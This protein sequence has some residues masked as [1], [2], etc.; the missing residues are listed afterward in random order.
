MHAKVKTEASTK[1]SKVIKK[2]GKVET[3]CV[4]MRSPAWGYW[5]FREHWEAKSHRRFFFFCHCE[6]AL[7]GQC[8]TLSPSSLCLLP[9]YEVGLL[10]HVGPEDQ[11]NP[12]YIELPNSEWAIIKL[13]SSRN[14]YCGYFIIVTKSNRSWSHMVSVYLFGTLMV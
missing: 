14:D 3:P 4:K 11:A 10:Y 6:Y 9:D 13:F 1:T 8:R 12:S 7:E 2:F 5:E